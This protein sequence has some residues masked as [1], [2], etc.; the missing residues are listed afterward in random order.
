MFSTT[1]EKKRAEQVLPGSWVWGD[2]A[3]TMYTH[4]NKCKNNEMKNKGFN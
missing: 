3:Q 1:V 4:V 2:V